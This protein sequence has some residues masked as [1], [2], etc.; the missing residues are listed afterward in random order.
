MSR[1]VYDFT[2][3]S[4]DQKDL[5]GG[6]GA[7]LAE[8][9]R[10]GLP[11]PPGF[12]IS[13]EACRAYLR[14]GNV[15]SGLFAEV[16]DHLRRVETQL[17]KR[18]DD[19]HD[20]LLLSVRSGGKF[21][22]P[23]MMETILDIGL[24]DASVEGLAARSGDERFAWDSYRRLIQMLGR[25]VFDVPAA[26]FET[27][28][29][30]EQMGVAELRDLVEAHKKAFR[31]Y[32]GR[33][34]P[35][36]PHEQ[37]FLAITAVFRSWNAERA[38]LY[39]RQERIPQDLGTA[40]NVM[41]MV[42]GNR[43]PDSGTGVAFTRDPATGR[44]GVYGDYL[45]N[46]Q[47]EDVVAGIRNTVSLSALAGIDPASYR[48]LLSIMERLEQRYRDLCDIEFTIENGKLWMLQTRVGKRTPAAAFVI[49]AQ[50][51]D[52]SVIT[53]DEALLR[54][55]GEQLAHLMFPSF[56][57]AAAPPA[58]TTGVPA[59]PG[60]ASGA[61]VFDS[62]AA[63][64]ATGPVILVRR[65][66]NPDDLPGMIAAQGILTSRGGKTSHAAVVARGMGQ[67]C[68]CGAEEIEVGDGQFTVG[69][70]VV[71]AGE[72][73]SIDGTTGRVY[74][75]ELPVRPSPVVRFFEGELPPH[76]DQLLGA[77]QRL[78]THAGHVARL[79]VHANADTARDA[80]RARRYGATGVGL[81]R[82]EHMFLGDRRVLVE[83][84]I[85]AEDE[86]ERDAALA[87]LLPLQRADFEDLLAAMDGQPVTIRLIDPPLHEFLPPLDELAARVATAEARGTDPGRDATLLTAVRRMH[88]ANP[89][90]GL[91]GVRLGLVIPG[92]FAM[93]I[94]AV[95]EA[96]ARRVTAGGDPRPEIMIPLVGT[97]QELETVR[98]EAETVLAAVTGASRIPIG[99][100][101]E[102]P[103]AA[104]T[105]G[106]IAHAA[107]FFSFGTNDLTQMTW[108]FSRD[109]VE[110][111]FFGRYLSL[112]IF[113][114]SP[115]ETIDSGGVGELVRIAVE[116]G[117]A[118][119]PNLTMGVCGEH[120]GDPASIRF[121][122]EAGLDYVSCSPFRVPIAR[123]E[124]GRAAVAESATASDSR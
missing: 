54:V 24:S 78:M 21:S 80:A 112:G 99:T 23:G 70:R 39:R 83:R 50:L 44:R 91:R 76:G 121:F 118:A 122:H 84:L 93:Q 2:E 19:A 66:T 56:D 85:L 60:A 117:R 79:G 33:E 124:A 27:G 49:A 20:P 51:V 55:N 75:G 5:L 4:K 105:A 25:T 120:G 65:E 102:V 69:G 88:E 74:A 96:A 86:V 114:V 59:S 100:M 1:Y 41:A 81:C 7:N 115:F 47:G 61:V 106:E 104:L 40:V 45:P 113:A 67:T 95:A 77:I 35:Q 72:I 18:L 8:M 38:V 10:M 107:E 53:L 12:T 36:A 42:F 64:A 17:G 30:T 98:A 110:G 43:G 89:M 111:A 68:V 82:T 6:K 62:A 63:S 119:R 116:R 32:T 13:T 103:R 108:G 37:L 9:T 57:L 22:M 87:D 29:P 73:I 90:L 15:P 14:T 31:A 101:I 94:R 58:L 97:V 71:R 92:L 123:L 16:E 34:F 28:S 3:G 52:E 26:E 11:V 46:A 109:D 48:Q